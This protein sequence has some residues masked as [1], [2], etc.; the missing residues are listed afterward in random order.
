VRAS[1]SSIRR[2]VLLAL[3]VCFSLKSVASK[4]HF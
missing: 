2:V 3:Q 4:A 1:V